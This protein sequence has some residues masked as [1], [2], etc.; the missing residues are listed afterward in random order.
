MDNLVSKSDAAQQAVLISGG[1]AGIGLA[2]V[3]LFRKLGL[4][5][6]TFGKSI[7]HVARL[8]DEFEHDPMIYVD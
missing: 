4:K 5:V 2:L 3:R 6:S 8:K 7:G 1:T